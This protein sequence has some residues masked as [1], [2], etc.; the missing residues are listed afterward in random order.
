MARLPARGDQELAACSAAGL[1]VNAKEPAAG[2]ALLDFLKSPAAM[3][4]WK[5]NGLEPP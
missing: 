1:S 4:V 5:E 3:A 2:R